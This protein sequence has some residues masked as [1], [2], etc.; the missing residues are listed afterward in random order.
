MGHLTIEDASIGYDTEG[1]KIALDNI[2]SEVIQKATQEMD[3]SYA[4]LQEKV[5]QF[6]IGQAAVRFKDN[7]LAEKN[8]VQKGMEDCYGALEGELKEIVSALAKLDSELVTSRP[9]N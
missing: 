6:M 3:K 9:E 2:H 5:F 7:I 1:I 4:D 8:I